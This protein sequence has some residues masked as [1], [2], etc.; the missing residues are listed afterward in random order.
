MALKTSTALINEIP[1]YQLNIFTND[2][3]EKLDVFFI[4]R[5]LEIAPVRIDVPY[6]SNFYA[7]GI[8]LRGEAELK[9]NLENYVIKPGSLVV[10]TGV[11]DSAMDAAVG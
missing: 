1:T 11:C 6:R 9:A 5:R 3:A 2:G 8:C 7:V 10:K 4:D